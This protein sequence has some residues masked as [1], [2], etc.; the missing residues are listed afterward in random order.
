MRV[1]A[2]TVIS[3]SLVVMLALFSIAC[4]SDQQSGET[5]DAPVI[6]VS[7][8][9]LT[10]P[11]F[12]ELTDAIREE[13]QQ[14]GYETI[15]TSCEF[16]AARQKNQVS[17]FVVRNVDAIILAPCDS[18]AVGTAIREANN[19]GIPVFTADI[20]SLA[21]N[22]RVVSHVAT[23]N[24]AGGQRAAE[25][26][27]EAID[28]HGKVAIIDHPEVESVLLRTNGFRNAIEEAKAENMAKDTIERAIKKGTGELEGE[29]YEVSDEISDAHA[30]HERD[31]QG[32]HRIRGHIGGRL[33]VHC[34]GGN[35]Q[36][37]Q[38]REL[39]RT[40]DGWSEK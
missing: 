27:L 19:A 23:D 20:A 16:D 31:V 4:G 21:D 14:L 10:H 25:A 7:V 26:I 35:E 36:E 9:T 8:L 30:T 11:F 3:L 28:R 17:D 40:H 38:D 34:R 22:A 1:R 12:Q 5:E 29:E 33:R 6:G 2:A 13:A 39:K 37:R 18:K 32:Q 24:Y 15:I